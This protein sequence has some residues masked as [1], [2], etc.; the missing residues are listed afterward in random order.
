[1]MS[2]SNV[3]V[4]T[5]QPLAIQ[6]SLSKDGCGSKAAFPTKFESGAENIVCQMR[7]AIQDHLLVW[8]Y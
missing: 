3:R 7:F 2:D 5:I 1:M 4:G 8:K 6:Y